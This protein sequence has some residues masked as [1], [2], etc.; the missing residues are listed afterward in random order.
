M[1]QM[2]EPEHDFEGFPDC[3]CHVSIFKFYDYLKERSN[4]INFLKEHQL[5]LKRY[6]CPK[7]GSECQLDDLRW[8]WRC[9]KKADKGKSGKKRAKTCNFSRPSFKGA[10]LENLNEKSHILP[11]DN[12]KFIQIYLDKCF[13]YHFIR[14][15]IGWAQQTVADWVSFSREVLEFHCTE[16]RGKI[17]GVGLTVEIDESKFGKRKY[18]RGHLVEGQWVFGGICRETRDFFMV[19]VEARNSR[20]LLPIIQNNVIPGTKIISDCW[21]AYN[22]LGEEGYEHLTVNHTYNF[23]DPDT[24]AHTNTIERSWRS[25]KDSFSVNSRRKSNYTGYL[26]RFY[27]LQKYRNLKQRM[28]NFCLAAAKLYPPLQ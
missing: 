22:C 19:P 27:F 8:L 24:G 12:L 21:R 26:A 23:V 5:I 13:S 18:S 16:L 14:R 7:C 11:A 17:G 2:H 3:G 28:H 6:V 15:E 10:W 1:G 4:V 25:A 20:T 9:Q